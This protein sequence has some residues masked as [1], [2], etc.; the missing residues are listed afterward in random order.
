[1]KNFTYKTHNFCSLLLL[2]LRI[3]E[4]VKCVLNYYND[5]KRYLR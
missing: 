5:T 2:E 3:I 1:M 4:N